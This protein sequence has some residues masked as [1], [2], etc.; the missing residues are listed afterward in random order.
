M[1]LLSQIRLNQGSIDAIARGELTRK[2]STRHL[3]GLRIDGI[4]GIDEIAQ[5][6]I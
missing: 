3:L 2:L 4:D 6:D 5:S 1:I